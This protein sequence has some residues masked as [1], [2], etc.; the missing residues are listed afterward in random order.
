MTFLAKLGGI[1]AKVLQVVTAIEPVINAV[2]PNSVQQRIVPVENTVNSELTDIAGEL[3]AAEQAYQSVTAA[4]GALNDAQ[5]L[6]IAL[7]MISQVVLTSPFLQ[8][9]KIANESG[10]QT[11]ITNLSIAIQDILNSTEA[12]TKLPA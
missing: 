9:K 11:G 8:N 7:P 3:A 10:F 12:T 5:K 2:L 4:G 6:A 1:L